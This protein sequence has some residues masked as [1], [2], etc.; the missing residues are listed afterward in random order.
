L[1]KINP[2]QFTAR[3]TG[4]IVPWMVTFRCKLWLYRRKTRPNV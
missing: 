2:G 4:L 1:L 3:K